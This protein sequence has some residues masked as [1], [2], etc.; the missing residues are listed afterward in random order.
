[1]SK[2][3]G[4]KKSI[5]EIEIRVIEYFLC[6]LYRSRKAGL[7]ILLA[8]IKSFTQEEG[9]AFEKRVKDILENKYK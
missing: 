4:F 7:C 1:M 9:I 6:L 5:L 2:E 3:Q 8:D